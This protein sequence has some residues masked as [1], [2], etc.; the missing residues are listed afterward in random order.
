LIVKKFNYFLLFKKQVGV[1]RI[2]KT[3]LKYLVPKLNLTTKDKALKIAV[4]NIKLLI[5][6]S[7]SESLKKFQ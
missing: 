6:N 2:K 1:I 3:Q 5:L 7:S 4:K